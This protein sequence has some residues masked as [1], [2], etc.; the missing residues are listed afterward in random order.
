V[1]T[2]AHHLEGGLTE[3]ILFIRHDLRLIVIFVFVRIDLVVELVL[4]LLG[5]VLH[6]VR[7]L[8]LVL[9]D[10]EGFIGF[11]LLFLC[12]RARDREVLLEDLEQFGLRIFGEAYVELVHNLYV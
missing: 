3:I 6:L 12:F 10:V 2:V 11:I 9:D 7:V 8:V 5:L 4:L 1:G